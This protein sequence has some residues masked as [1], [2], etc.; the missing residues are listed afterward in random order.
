MS[1]YTFDQDEYLKR[2]NFNGT[3]S[4]D[5]EFL[6][7]IHLAQHRTIP[8][9]NFDICLGKA[10][11]L[12][13]QALVN[14]I[15]KNKR[16][17]YCFELN[18]L[19]LMALK[20]F[21][22]EVRALLGRVH[23]SEI[24][25]GRGHQVTLVSIDGK[26][27]IVDL[28]FGSNTP[29]TPI[30]FICNQPIS[31]ESRTYRIIASELYGYMLQSMLGEEWQNLYSFDLSHVCQNDIGHG[32]HYTST[33]QKSFFT[34]SRIAARPVEYGMTSLFNYNLKKIIHGVE[35]NI[36]IEEG[37]SYIDMLNKEFGIELKAKYEDL[38]RLK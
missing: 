38:N 20:S 28:A 15:I 3:P 14:K 16:G 8:F 35:E 22:F 7:S 27:W 25:T 34:F 9:E 37:Q 13:P 4:Q 32:N 12:E 31:F 6:K 24:P 19:F 2:I 11:D 23:L 10:I 36:I 29:I 33:C 17:G 30:P 21:G 26:E 18:G 5:F 1:E